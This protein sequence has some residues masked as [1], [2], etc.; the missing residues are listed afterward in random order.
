MDSHRAER[1]SEALRE[2]LAEIIGFEMADPRLAN[3][4]VSEV[5][6][7]P[8]LRHAHVMVVVRGDENQ[9][10]EALESLEVARHYLRRELS[11]RLRMFRVPEL[12]F[13]QDTGTGGRIEELLDRVRKSRKKAA[14]KSGEKNP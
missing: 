12:H 11:A 9:S 4:T 2:E 5:H 8:D 13:E 3:V 14:E 7:M 10:R 6:V 1:V